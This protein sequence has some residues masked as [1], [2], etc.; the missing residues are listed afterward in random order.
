M[1]SFS[2]NSFVD[3]HE[4]CLVYVKQCLANMVFCSLGF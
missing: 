2:S 3:D 1:N 4:H